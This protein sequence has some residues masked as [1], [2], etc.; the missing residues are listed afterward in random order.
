MHIPTPSPDCPGYRRPHRH[1][2]PRWHLAGAGCRLVCPCARGQKSPPWALVRRFPPTR[3]G[4]EAASPQRWKRPPAA[5]S[6]SRSM[7]TPCSAA[8]TRCSSPC[9]AARKTSTWVRWP[10]FPPARR[11][12][13]F[14]TFPSCLAAYAEAAHL[15]D[16]PVGRKMLDG[17][18]ELD[19]QGLV[20]AGGA[21]RNMSNS[22][23]P[24]T[25]MADMKVLKVRARC[26]PHG[27]GQLQCH[28]HERGTHGLSRGIP[29]TGNQGAGRV[30]S[31]LW[32]TCMPT[33][34]TKCRST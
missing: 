15:L 33:K 24:L 16:G 8:R 1:G 5:R 23:R 28:G 7:A 10:P 11:K 26:K 9:K 27:V 31:T 30:R 21:F 18:G 22:K 14:L 2:R 13:R 4:H 32:S 20:W 34:C 12:C 17:L 3:P 25:T 29:G 19:V 6:P